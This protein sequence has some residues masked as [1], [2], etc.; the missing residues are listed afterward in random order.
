MNPKLP[1][2]LFVI[3]ALTFALSC[4]RSSSH[5]KPNTSYNTTTGNPQPTTPSTSSATTTERT[6]YDPINDKSEEGIRLNIQQANKS[7]TYEH[8]KKNADRYDGEPWTFIG[9]VFQI[10]ESG[11]QT[12]ALISL[13]AWGN[14]TMWVRA[15]FTTDFVEKDQVYVVGYLA[16]N[17]SYT[18]VAGWNITVPAMDARAILKPSDAARIKA[19]KKSP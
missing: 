12:F 2:M 16:G 4:D 13:D 19:G 14:K 6:T 5:V 1:L 15:N 11:G 8:L 18:S 17:H 10:Q 7:I 9:K 3:F